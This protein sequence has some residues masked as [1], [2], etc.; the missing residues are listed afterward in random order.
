MSRKLDAWIAEHVMGLD[1]WLS[2][3]LRDSGNGGPIIHNYTDGEDVPYYST[4]IAAAWEVVD[5]I[6][7]FNEYYLRKKPLQ[8]MWTI[9][10]NHGQVGLH[11][12]IIEYSK[13]APMAICLAAYKLKTGRNWDEDR[14]G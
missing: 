12:E 7:L 1:V 4:D 13:S 5:K 11:E 6:G 14:E 2:P 9:E 8:D 10:I 3:D